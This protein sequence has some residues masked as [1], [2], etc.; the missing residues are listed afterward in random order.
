MVAELKERPPYVVFETRPVHDVE[1]S[2]TEGRAVYVDKDFAI[3]TPIGGKDVV[4]REVEDWFK[5]MKRQIDEERLP[6]NWLAHFKELYGMWKEGHEIPL[7]GLSVK[8][9]PIATPSEV[10]TLL[11]ANIR[12][13]E[14]LARANE[15]ALQRIGMGS[16]GLKAKAEAYLKSADR[17]KAA[18]EM[19]KL[20]KEL[21]AAKLRLQAL[22]RENAKLAES[23][24]AAA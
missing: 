1:A 21:E 15:E 5:N 10:K 8:M 19:D 3:I 9:W 11:D 22:E 24:K 18:E 13:V 2:Q 6:A 4:H 17:G 14:D 7:N 23:V 12:T 20:R 16:R